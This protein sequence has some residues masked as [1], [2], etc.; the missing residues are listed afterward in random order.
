VNFVP[1]QWWE[2][3]SGVIRFK[4]KEEGI[5]I[6]DVISKLDDVKSWGFDVVEIFAPYH[7]GNEYAGL[8]V[9]DYFRV[10]PAIGAM[11]EFLELINCAHKKGIAVIIFINL[12][13]CAM[14]YPPFIKACEDVRRGID[15]P[16]THLFLWSNT[17]EDI[18]DKSLA[19]YF[20]NDLD[21]SW[22]FNKKAGKY[23]WVKWRG[24][25]GDAALPQ[26][27][28]G[29]SIWRKKCKQIIR[30]WMEIGIDGMIIDAVNWYMNCNWEINY[31]TITEVIHRYPNKYIQ[32]EGAGG[33]NDDPVQWILRGKYNSVQDYGINIW[34]ENRDVIGKA[35]DTGDPCFIE[36]ALQSYRDRVV[37][38]GGVTYIGPYWN[39]KVSR[40]QRRLEIA[41]LV[42]IG[43]FFH[44]DG[45]LLKLNWPQGDILIIKR[46]MKALQAHPALQASG[47][48]HRLLTNDDHK[49]YAFTRTSKDGKERMLV[50]LNFQN[51]TQ[52]VVVQ[53]HSPTFLRDIFS[54]E[55]IRNIL[56]LQVILPPYGYR[57][58]EI[59][60]EA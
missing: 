36:E 21:G 53:L 8:D 45:K 9:I 27:N 46:L 13:Y 55:K 41:T 16:E 58:Y 17:G 50:I 59:T 47:N 35:I 28:F 26:F 39:K 6:R 56:E 34:W 33:F 3:S 24:I 11:D 29:S 40:E 25:S 52:E 12:G 60:Q 14:H 51:E 2:K 42:T 49:F 23:Y 44:D 4:C 57:I 43:E 22:H 54:N 10:D 5:T 18:F 19:P 32:P 1:E 15:S 48:R 38:A 20:M 37:A 30:F 31:Q 7:G